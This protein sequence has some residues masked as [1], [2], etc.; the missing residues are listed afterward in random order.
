MS[1]KR[2][3]T[4]QRKEIFQYLVATQD[5]PH[6]TVPESKQKAIKHFAITESQLQQIEE[7]GLDKE[8]PPLGQTVEE[9]LN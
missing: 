7:E 8:W 3:N 1:V 9:V 6:M 2:L 4:E 5:R